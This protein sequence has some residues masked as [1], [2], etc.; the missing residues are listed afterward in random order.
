MLNAYDVLGVGRN[1]TPEEIKAA[2]RTMAVKHHPDKG[3]DLETMK[4]VNQARD[5]LN[6]PRLKNRLDHELGGAQRTAAPGAAPHGSDADRYYRTWQAAEAEARAERERKQ[7]QARARQDAEDREWGN[8][9]RRETAEAEAEYA[10]KRDTRDDVPNRAFRRFT[11]V[12]GRSSKFWEVN[13]DGRTMTVRWGRIASHGQSKTKTYD[14]AAAAFTES[15]KLIHSKLAKGYREVTRKPTGAAYGGTADVGSSHGPRPGDPADA[16]SKSKGAKK[17][18]YKV[19][20][21][22]ADPKSKSGG[23][24]VH[25]RVKGD[26]YVPR[27]FTSRARQNSQVNVNVRGDGRL[28]VSDPS[29]DWSQVWDRNESVEL[30]E[31]VLCELHKLLEARK[32]GV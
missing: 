5:I 10:R 30:K 22:A 20:G 8:K 3:G 2:W 12:A 26:V 6:T 23:A 29:G 1:A 15:Q 14:S 31:L 24:D 18:T 4:S 27:D 16:P 28:G 25:T 32:K 9:S 11:Y 17:T 21:R 19:Y 7:R 13:V